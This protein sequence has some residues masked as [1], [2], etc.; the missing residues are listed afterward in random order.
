MI[1][2][3]SELWRVFHYDPINRQRRWRSSRYRSK[4]GT[5]AGHTNKDGY[6]ELKCVIH[7]KIYAFSLE[8]A[9]DL[10]VS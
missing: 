10:W 5:V 4:I 1:P 6:H 8:R 7:G 3:R 9:I 2:P